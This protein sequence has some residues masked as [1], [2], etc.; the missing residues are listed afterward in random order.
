M[1]VSTAELEDVILSEPSGIIAD[2]GVAGV[3]L[4]SARMSD[5]KSPRA[6]VVLSPKGKEVGEQAA[7]ER[8]NQWVQQNLSKYKWLRGGVKIIGKV[9]HSYPNDCL[10]V[11]INHL[12]DS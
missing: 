10:S 5:D 9:N 11:L 2:V 3:Q 1:Q 8:I 6:W 7:I 4:P 12:Q